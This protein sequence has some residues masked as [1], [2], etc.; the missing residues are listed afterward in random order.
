[1]SLAVGTW[2]RPDSRFKSLPK[3]MDSASPA[4]PP[5]IFGRVMTPIFPRSADMAVPKSSTLEFTRSRTEPRIE[6]LNVDGLEMYDPD[7]LD[8]D[9]L[10]CESDAISDEGETPRSRAEKA[11]EFEVA[12][13]WMLKE[14][15]ERNARKFDRTKRKLTIC[16]PDD[17]PLEG[18]N[19][20][21]EEVQSM[22]KP[23]AEL[24]GFIEDM[25][26]EQ[27]ERIYRITNMDF[28]TVSKERRK[29]WKKSDFI[30]HAFRMVRMMTL[31]TSR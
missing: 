7:L 25:D 27:R 26:P 15:T 6:I 9:D 21:L 20:R 29:N 5:R 1:M 24:S 30:K 19:N 12:H 8:G 13:N 2:V 28:H 23:K 11:A 17:D 16:L 4:R 18:I 3:L 10:D 22:V 14:E 31:A